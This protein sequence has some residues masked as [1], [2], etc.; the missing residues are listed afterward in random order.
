MLRTDAPTSAAA[1]A[2]RQARYCEMLDTSED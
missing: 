1:E 2:M